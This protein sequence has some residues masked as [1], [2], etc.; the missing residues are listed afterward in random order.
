MNSTEAIFFDAALPRFVSAIAEALGDEVLRDGLVLRDAN[1][2]LSFV[3]AGAAPAGDREPLEK[4]LVGSIGAYAQQ[5]RVLAFGDEP[6]AARVLKDSAVFPFHVE[7]RTIR[8]LDR[9]IVGSAWLDDPRAEAEGPARIVF[10]S[11][12]GGVGRSTALAITASDL[13]RRNK[14]VLMI[15]LD[16]EAPGL[17]DLLL[18]ADRTP[19]FGSLDFLVENGI[20]GVPD[21]LLDDFIGVSAL[22]EPGGGRVDVLP[23]LGRSAIEQPANMLAKLS[24]AMIDDLEADGGAITVAT[25]I[26]TMISRFTRRNNYDVVL[27]DSRAGLSELA[28]PAILG[29]G[30]TTLLFGTAQ[31]QTIQGYSALFAGL[32]LLAERDKDA[33]QSAEWRFLLKAVYAK[34]SLEPNTASRYRDELYDLFAENLYDADLGGETD[35]DAIS[36]D[37]DD[38]TAPHWPLV[39]PFNAG[40]VDFDPV[41]APNQ[42]TASFYEQ[43]YRPFL[44]GIDA[45]IQT[46]VDENGALGS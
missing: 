25:Q 17:G 3:S 15:D 11:L 10:A 14:N 4:K 42:L 2:R 41:H 26:A 5:E 36:F 46:H 23:A 32:K 37:I 29:L 31:R 24:R 33:G 27:I 20:G 35:P 16:L 30:A 45:I 34:A 19:L 38:N 40:M 22:T 44:D 1:G 6:G 28:A 13:A 8:L 7:G 12:K 9:R 21:G 18:D 39:I 43:T